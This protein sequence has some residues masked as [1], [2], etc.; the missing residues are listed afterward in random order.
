[1]SLTACIDSRGGDDNT[2]ELVK[3]PRDE[4]LDGLRTSRSVDEDDLGVEQDNRWS[5]EE[6]LACSLEQLSATRSFPSKKMGLK[7]EHCI[8]FGMEKRQNSWRSWRPWKR[9]VEDKQ[10]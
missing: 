3:E 9:L 10:P 2:E 6:D 1:M 8:E 4:D 5:I 7:Q